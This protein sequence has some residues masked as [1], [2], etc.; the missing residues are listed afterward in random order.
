MG[1]LFPDPRLA[2]GDAPLAVGDDLSPTTLLEAYEQGIFPWPD[3]FGAV[4]WWS[5]DPRTVFE[6]G[7]VHRS[8]SLRRRMRNGGF[9]TTVDTAFD[10]V[11]AGCAVRP[12]EGTWITSGMRA[13]YAR[14]HRMD[15]AHSVEVWRG[16]ELVGGLYGVTV[17][18]VFTG[19][20]MFHTV[21]DA[22][23]VALVTLDDRLA[24]RGFALIDAQLPTDHLR[25]MG[26]VQ[27]PRAAFLDVLAEQRDTPASFR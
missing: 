21:A 10:E 25:S 3:G 18:G 2:P 6:V 5:P 13:A 7:S 9:T 22:S 1:G 26:A 12:R 23:K 16:G 8:R 17:G 27:I 11:M 14:L 24:E 4:F 19:E 15:R 20:S